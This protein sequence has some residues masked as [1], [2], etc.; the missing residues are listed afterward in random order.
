MPGAKTGWFSSL[1]G[2]KLAVEASTTI[3]PA[4]SAPSQ[5]KNWQLKLL[6]P[7]GWFLNLHHLPEVL[8][9]SEEAVTLKEKSPTFQNI[10]Y[11]FYLGAEGN[12][13]DHITQTSNFVSEK[14]KDPT[15]KP[16]FSQP[17]ILLLDHTPPGNFSLGAGDSYI[18]W[19]W[20]FGEISQYP[21]L[22]EKEGTSPQESGF[23]FNIWVHFL[24]KPTHKHN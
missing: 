16:L 21:C 4:D 20:C 17:G 19:S 1:T 18:T 5:V 12:L 23:S 10:E 8:K 13:R 9:D 2:Q 22:L 7:K 14:P 15:E 6:P 11:S 3:R 24:A